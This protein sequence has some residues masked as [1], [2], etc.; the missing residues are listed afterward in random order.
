[1]IVRICCSR[2]A[3]RT[4]LTDTWGAAGTSSGLTAPAGNPR[5]RIDYLMYAAGAGV[6]LSPITAQ[7][8]PSFVSD[9]RA[10]RATYR[11]STPGAEVCVPV[12]QEQDLP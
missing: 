7:V 3:A 5:V 10:V 6:D 12:L 2:A 9:H 1:M 8:L 4:A 11:V